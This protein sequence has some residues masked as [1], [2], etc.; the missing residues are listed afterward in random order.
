MPPPKKSRLQDAER[1]RA[2]TIWHGKLPG[3]RTRKGTVAPFHAVNRFEYENILRDLLDDPYLKI[4]DRILLDAE[5]HGF[6]KVGAA[7]DASHA[8]VNAYLDVAEFA[9]RRALTFLKRSPVQLPS[10]CM[11]ENREECGLQGG[12]PAWTRFSLALDGLEI[13]DKYSFRKLGLDRESK[14]KPTSIVVDDT[15]AERIGPWKKSTR[16]ANHLGKHYLATA[17]NKG[18][19]EITWK[20]VLPKPGVYEV[21]VSFCGGESLSKSALTPFIMQ[22]AKPNS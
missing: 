4:A 13:N 18:P 2:L 9:L 16:R 15:D 1:Q 6:A 21:R 10:V 12:N 17:K 11:P 3:L 7:L 8:Q 19:H 22:R 14:T 20:T 5:V